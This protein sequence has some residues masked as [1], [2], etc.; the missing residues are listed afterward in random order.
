[1]TILAL[2]HFTV[3]S[4]D[5]EASRDFY[6]G[7]LGMEAGARPQ[8]N[9]PGLWLYAGGVPILHLIGVEEAAA[10]RNAV[11]DHVALTAKDLPQTVAQFKAKDIKYRLRRMSDGSWQMFCRDPDGAMIEL[12]FDAS[13]KAPEGFSS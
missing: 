2:N 4:R 12:D 13:E 5:L 9:F 8:M 7:V 3:M 6:C 11:I 10:S 1:M